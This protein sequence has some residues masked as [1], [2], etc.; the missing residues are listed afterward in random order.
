MEHHS[1]LIFYTLHSGLDVLEYHSNLIFYTLHSGCVH[2]IDI[3]LEKAIVTMCRGTGN[4][5]VQG[6]S[7]QSSI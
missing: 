1:N 3:P 2:S 7:K 4:F 6:G 5:P